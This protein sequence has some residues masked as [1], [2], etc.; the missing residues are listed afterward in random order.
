[1]PCPDWGSTGMSSIRCSHTFG[2]TLG[3]GRPLVGLGCLYFFRMAPVSACSLPWD[4]VLVFYAFGVNFFPSFFEAL[5]GLTLAT[6]IT[7]LIHASGH[8]DRGWLG[9]GVVRT[10]YSDKETEAQGRGGLYKVLQS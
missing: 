5:L 10:H 7:G 6:E 4:S 9:V 3:S 2:M 8:G 1:M